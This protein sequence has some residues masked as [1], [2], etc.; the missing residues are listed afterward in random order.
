MKPTE[1]LKSLY[2]QF[3]MKNYAPWNIALAR[4]EGARVWDTEGR[5]YLDF[6]AGI[7]V[8]TLGHHHP[9]LV[10][11][12][13]DQAARVLHVSNL[14][15]NELQP[16]VAKLLVERSYQQG[17]VFFC[18]SG[19][20]ANEGLI[21]LARLW[22]KSHGNRYKIVS[23]KVSF[24]GRTLATLTATGQ[25]KVQ[26]GFEPL[27]EGFVYAEFNNLESVGTAVDDQT[28]AV[29][30]EAVQGEGGI[31]PA[32]AAFLQGLRQMCDAR[33]LLLLCDEVQCG[34]GRTGHWFGFQAAGIRPDAFSLAKGLGGGVPIGAVV[35]GPSLCDVFQPGHHGSTFGGNPLV[36]AAAK[37]VI[38]TMEDEGLVGHAARMGELFMS[39]LR[40][41]ANDCPWIQDVR[42]RGLMIGLQ[43]DRPCAPLEEILRGLGLIALTTSYTVLRFVPPLNITEAEVRQAAALVR[44]ACATWMA[45]A[46]KPA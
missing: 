15:G 37:A 38:E 23:M 32:T 41:A 17:R 24:H 31:R 35:A 5:E 19:A 46:T 25:A 2:G 34:M 42:G 33:G 36:C 18:N 7:A 45:T 10:K 20:E 27:P 6:G 9:R 1:E 16:V 28:A 14:Y 29:L 44:Q 39:L 12:I 3:V 40:E 21:K 26:T 8:S 22:G 11:A 30:V 4:G 43:F 13:A